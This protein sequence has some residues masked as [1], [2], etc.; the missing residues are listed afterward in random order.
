MVAGVVIRLFRSC[1]RPYGRTI[2]VITCLQ[3]AQSV[4]ALSLPRLSADV[5]DNGVTAGDTGHLLWTGEVMIGLAVVQVACTVAAVHL[6]ARTAMAV[7]RD[8]R[9]SVFERAL[10]LSVHRVDTLGVPSLVTRTTNDV[11]QVQT[12]VLML[13]TLTLP[14]P[15]LCC[16]AVLLALGQDAPFSLLLLGLMAVLAVLVTLL[17][18]RTHP[19]FQVMQERIDVVNRVLREQ[20][21]GVRVVRAF[22][23]DG[24]E[25][26]RFQGANDRLADVSI[27]AGRHTTL[28]IPML[29]TAV[30]LASVPLVWL[31][32]YRIG[33]GGM[34]V[35]ELIAFLGYL[36]LVLASIMMIA[37]LF[38]MLPRARVCAERIDE[39]LD[40][41]PGQRPE[42]GRVHRLSLP[43]RL[44]LRGAGFRYPG[45]EVPVFGGVDLTV[46]PC[47]TLA[48]IGSTGSGKSTLLGLV[49]GLY[50]ATS[51]Q[52]LV[53]GVDV[54]DLAPELL[55]RTVGLVPQRPH[56]FSGTVAS[57]LRHGRPQATEAELWHALEVAQARDFVE[58]LD[59]GLEASVSP[60]GA[61]LSMGQRQRMTIART[62][63][64]RP[65]IYLFDDSFTALDHDTEAALRGALEQEIADATVVIV[66]QRVNTIRTADR[67]AVLDQGRVVAVGAH[68]ELMESDPTYREIVRS[69]L[70][71][72]EAA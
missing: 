63:V 69:Q 37:S 70:T 42:G 46:R 61:N 14:A 21:S 52:V 19:L 44:E 49:P 13:L 35:G 28:M 9:A 23:R 57:N 56:L 64:R 27:S 17:V 66:A 54:R 3:I 38:V 12:L 68:H 71:G 29:T 26:R 20:I 11:Q 55:S 6:G 60:G 15:F 33:D 22:V 67:I 30:N 36:A 65:E 4:A 34:R 50:E 32:A 10:R 1:L 40:A 72:E 18:R 45:A 62:L 48:I 24:H 58:R 31:G 25:R 7:G 16:G 53:G 2:A 43:G 8:L 59:D 47:E 51:G 5:V 39:V 41:E